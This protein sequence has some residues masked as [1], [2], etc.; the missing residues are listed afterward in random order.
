M[1]AFY[2]CRDIYEATPKDLLDERGQAYQELVAL[3]DE[4]RLQR[5]NV[6][7]HIFT[8]AIYTHRNLNTVEG[9]SV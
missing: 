7:M 2:G 8:S 9:K 5:I 3:L 6:S 1:Y 4:C